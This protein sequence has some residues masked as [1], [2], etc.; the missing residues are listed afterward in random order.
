MVEGAVGGRAP[1]RSSDAEVEG[2]DREAHRAHRVEQGKPRAYLHAVANEN[3]L[4]MHSKR[5]SRRNLST[6][7]VEVKLNAGS[8]VLSLQEEQ[9]GDHL[10][11]GFGG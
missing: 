5:E 8:A 11:T 7:A 10:R 2:C 6:R 1:D 4:N 3:A 9:D